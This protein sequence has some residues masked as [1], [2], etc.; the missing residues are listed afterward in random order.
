MIPRVGLKYTFGN[1]GLRKY[2][3]GDGFKCFPFVSFDGPHTRRHYNPDGDITSEY[4]DDI[5]LEKEEKDALEALLGVWGVTVGFGV[6]Y[7]LSEGFSIGGEC[8]ARM[9]FGSADHTYIEPEGAGPEDWSETWESELSV[10]LK[11]S[12]AAIVLSFQL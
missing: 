6:E 2:F 12:Y 4:V 10:S 5:S 11:T 7:P 8:G 9:Y 3:F 1:S